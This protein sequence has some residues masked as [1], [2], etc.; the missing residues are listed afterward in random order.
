MLKGA[1]LSARPLYSL[2]RPS[3]V[4]RQ[5]GNAIAIAAIMVYVQQRQQLRSDQG[6]YAPTRSA[7][8]YSRSVSD[9]GLASQNRPG[10]HRYRRGREDC[11]WLN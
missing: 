11:V 3:K 1:L 5:P 2:L 6:L 4:S 9:K 10:N 7:T 8:L